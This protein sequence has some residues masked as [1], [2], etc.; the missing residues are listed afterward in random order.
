LNADITGK[1]HEKLIF[2]ES[3]FKTV[4]DYKK[5]NKEKT[6]REE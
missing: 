4:V 6:E 2:D 1:I 5:Y 3:L